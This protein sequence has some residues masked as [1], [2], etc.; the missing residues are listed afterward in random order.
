MHA[1]VEHATV[2]YAIPQPY[3]VVGDH[4]M[5]SA[6]LTQNALNKCLFHFQNPIFQ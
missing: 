4:G 5:Q 2:S 6:N 1:D 3:S